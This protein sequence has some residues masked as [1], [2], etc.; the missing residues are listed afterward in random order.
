MEWFSKLAPGEQLAL[1]IQAA[2]GIFS[3]GVFYATVR[4]LSKRV[5]KVEDT[6]K[7]HEE[8][9]EVYGQDLEGLKVHTRY[10]EVGR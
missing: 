8:K 2:S 7:K 1:L 3:A 5:A 9:I 6:Q 10:R 4:F